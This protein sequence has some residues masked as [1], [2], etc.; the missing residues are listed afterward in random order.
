DYPLLLHPQREQGLADCVDQLLRVRVAQVLA[1]EMDVSA[2]EMLAQAR[3][4]VQRSRAAY[5]RVAV[6]RQLELE[7]RV[8][9]GLVPDVLELLERA[10]QRLGHVLAAEGAEPSPHGVAHE[11]CSAS[12]TAWMKARI[13]SGSLTRTLDSTPLETSTPDGRSFRTTVP[14]LPGSSPPAMK[15]FLS[16]SRSRASSHV[17]VLPVPPRWSCDHESSMI[18]S[19]HRLASGISAAR[20]FSTFITGRPASKPGGSDPC[21][22]SRSSPTSPAT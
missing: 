9:L 10:H 1:L 22:C 21:S 20:T 19:G 2:A 15:T 17:H 5:E 7:L 6:A 18:G 3:S 12:R 13:F 8:G 11:D 14:T 4:R 16:L